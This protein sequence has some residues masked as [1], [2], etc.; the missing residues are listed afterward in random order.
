LDVYLWTTMLPPAIK[1]PKVTVRAMHF[2]GSWVIFYSRMD[3]SGR[4]TVPRLV[5]NELLRTAPD[6]RSLIGEAV[7]VRLEPA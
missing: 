2:F 3:K 7:H 6:Q 4:I 5:Q 1:V